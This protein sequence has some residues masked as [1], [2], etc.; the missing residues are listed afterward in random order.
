MI[1]GRQRHFWRNVSFQDRACV[2]YQA[3]MALRVV[4]TPSASDGAVAWT[5]L[6]LAITAGIIAAVRADRLPRGRLR[7]VAYRAGI[8]GAMVLSYFSLQTVLP[9]LDPVPLDRSLLALDRALFGETPALALAPLATNVALV[10]WFSFFYFSYYLLL[11]LGFLPALWSDRGS[12]PMR[13]LFVGATVIS[14]LGYATY[15]LVPGLGPCATVRFPAPL[16]GGPGWQVV[17]SSVDAA[18]AKLDI[19]PS[20]HTAFPTFLALHARAHRRRLTGP[21]RHG[22]LL[23]AFFALNIVGA[24]MLLRWH[25][26]IDVIAGLALAGLARWAA[27]KVAEQERGRAV[28]GLQPVWP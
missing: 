5:L 4:G 3:F 13:E 20:L 12:R 15:T 2:V 10:E 28:I 19:F 21:R 11:A 18:G 24:T 17:R 27:V 6:L 8:F 1:P 22:W 14:C 16:V 26:G 23:W 9:A 25:Y 7:S